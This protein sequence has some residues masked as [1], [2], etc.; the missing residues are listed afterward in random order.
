M[1]NSAKPE[2]FTLFFNLALDKRQIPCS[3]PNNQSRL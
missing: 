2:I 3:N 1:K